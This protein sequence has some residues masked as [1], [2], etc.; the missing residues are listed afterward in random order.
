[1]IYL[2]YG[3]FSNFERGDAHFFGNGEFLVTENAQ[4]TDESFE[5][6][7]CVF[8]PFFFFFF[9]SFLHTHTKLNTSLEGPLTFWG[10]SGSETD[11]Y[12]VRRS[13]TEP[14]FNLFVLTRNSELSHRLRPWGGGGEAND[15]GPS[16][17]GLRLH[18]DG[19]L[20]IANLLFYRCLL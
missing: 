9:F 10:Y 19:W 16:L 14:V 2:E 17:H 12:E 15:N 6:T 7:L 1:M 11:L 3:I 20:F 4:R 18:S 13:S 8:S 5:C